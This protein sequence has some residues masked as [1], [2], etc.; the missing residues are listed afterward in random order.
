MLLSSV[1]VVEMHHK[2]GCLVSSLAI[3]CIEYLQIHCTEFVRVAAVLLW[4]LCSMGILESNFVQM[5]VC[6]WQTD[7]NAP[8]QMH[9]WCIYFIWLSKNESTPLIRASLFFTVLKLIYPVAATFRRISFHIYTT[10]ILLF[11]VL[12]L[13]IK[14]KVFSEERARVVRCVRTYDRFL[15]THDELFFAK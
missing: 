6:V 10:L 9:M 8:H 15:Y 14:Y 13:F 11:F 12:Y 2:Q 1:G 5:V 3:C 4:Y 7:W